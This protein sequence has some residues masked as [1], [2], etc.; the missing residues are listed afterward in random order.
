VSGGRRALLWGAVFAVLGFALWLAWPILTPFLIAMGV[1][2]V[3]DPLVERIEG[4]GYRR[5]T[6]TAW[7]TVAFGLLLV[8]MLAV[9]VP[10]LIQQVPG[11]IGFIIDSTRNAVDRARPMIDRLAQQLGTDSAG[12]IGQLPGGTEIATQVVGWLYA[13]LRGV[14]SGGLALL[15]LASLVFLTPVVVFYL[16]RD[17]PKILQRVESWL[18][19][20]QA[21]TIVALVREIDQRL[22]G[23]LRGQALVCLL[24]GAFYAVGL[25][26]AGLRYSILVGLLSGIVTFVP[27]I[28]VLAGAATGITMAVFQFSDWWWVG[29][30]AAVFAI[31]QFIEANFVSPKLIGE[32]VGLHPVWLMIA[33]LVGGV[34]GGLVGVMLAVPAAAAMGVLLRY[35]LARYLE[36]PLYL[37]RGLDRG[38]S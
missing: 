13:A 30:V 26:L 14:V 1:A 7:V 32:R 21:P 23:F 33:L 4:F 3:L 28:G 5:V 36:S 8:A 17:W 22:A 10:L 19:R 31:G 29:A 9:L 16:L 11:M 18:P 27:Y 35:A 12:L 2:Y 20:D 15:N 34:V 24:L 37:G 25:S 38:A 6:V